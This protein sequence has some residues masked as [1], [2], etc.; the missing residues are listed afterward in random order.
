[1][2]QLT[3]AAS[4]FSHGQE[5]NSFTL[6]LLKLSFVELFL[7]ILLS[8]TLRSHS[9]SLTLMLKYINQGFF[10]ILLL[11]FVTLQGTSKEIL[12]Y[13]VSFTILHKEGTQ[14]REKKEKRRQKGL[15]HCKWIS[16]YTIKE[17]L[18]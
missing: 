7:L 15:L 18:N 1:M 5:M 2:P 12:Y 6:W 16:T 13:N 3:I 17:I 4:S 9:H 10:C 14:K 8:Q 11:L